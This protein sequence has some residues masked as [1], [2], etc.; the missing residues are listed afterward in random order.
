M[1]S[2]RRGPG[3]LRPLRRRPGRAGHA[4]SATHAG[5]EARVSA[6]GAGEDQGDDADRARVVEVVGELPAARRAGDLAAESLHDADRPQA[7]TAWR[8]CTR[9]S[10]TGASSTSTDVR[11]R[12]IRSRSSTATARPAGKATRSSSTR[13]ASTSGRTSSRTAGSTATR[14]TSPNVTRRPSMNYLMVQITVDD[15][16]VLEKPWKSAH[17]PL[18]ARRRR[19][20]RVLLHQQQGAR[21]A[22][23]TPRAR[24]ATRQVTTSR[25]AAP[26]SRHLAITM[27]IHRS[28]E[29]SI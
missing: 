10:T 13:S 9:S 8:S 19:D 11:S 23:K 22:R 26:D 28:I 3:R 14:C 7:G 15:P 17:A 1:V 16:K 12:R 27:T 6:V 25:I 4:R 18:D 21:G 2:E 29:R 5:G 20:L 24:A